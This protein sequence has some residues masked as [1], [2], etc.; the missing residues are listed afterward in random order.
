[1]AKTGF[2]DNKKAEICVL[3]DFTKSASETIA[4]TIEKMKITESMVIKDCDNYVAVQMPNPITNLVA[5]YSSHFHP[6][7]TNVPGK[8]FLLINEQN[9]A[10]DILEKKIV[11]ETIFVGVYAFADVASFMSAYREILA[12]D[13]KGELFL[14]NVI[15]YMINRQKAMFEVLFASDYQDWGTLKE[16]EAIQKSMRTYFIDVDGVITK[17][18]GKYGKL[19]WSNNTTMLEANCITIKKL[20]DTGGQIVITTSR[21]EEYRSALERMLEKVGIKPYAILMGMNHSARVLINDFAAT[22]PYPSALAVS[23]PRNGKLQDYI[24]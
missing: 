10:Q 4:F 20:A 15:S 17:N 9:I 18:S 2:T 24:H 21:T 22:N 11:S 3:D 13:I 23:L 12:K 14:S 1:L 19:N 8:S 7:I 16:W 5:G 6:D